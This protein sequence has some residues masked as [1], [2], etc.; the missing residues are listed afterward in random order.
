MTRST[1]RISAAMLIS[2]ALMTAVSAQA[3]TASAPQSKKDLVAR[4]IQLQQ[5]AIA[6]IAD[7]IA[8]QT[9]RQIMQA[10]GP[11]VMQLPADKRDATGKEVQAQIKHFYDDIDGYL[12][13]RATKLAPSTM[14]PVLEEKF[15]DEELKQMIT[16][17]ESP[18]AK[19]LDEF[20]GT[21]MGNLEQKLIADTRPAVEPKI[22]AL[23]TQLRKTL[24]LPPAEA[25][26]G[27]KA[28]AKK[29][30]PATKK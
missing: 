30:A 25:A 16:W 12:K 9:A 26:S 6:N 4:V 10:A 21:M 19:K 14:G 7:T 11:A 28:P 23:Q 2:A 15:T 29:A 22:Q 1:L 8:G 24:G 27:A 3:A 18:A 17:L 5:G 20:G 13:D